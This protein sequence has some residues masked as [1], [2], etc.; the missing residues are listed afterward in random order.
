MI[1]KHYVWS[2]RDY[3]NGVLQAIATFSLDDA[4]DIALYRLAMAG[5]N[6]FGLVVREARVSAKKS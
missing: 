3:R 2:H 4:T 1:V 6:R 5:I